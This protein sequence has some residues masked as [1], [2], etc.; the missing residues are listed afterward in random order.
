[1]HLQSKAVLHDHRGVKGKL[2]NE[3]FQDNNN[4]IISGQQQQHSQL[5]FYSPRKS[6]FRDRG[7]VG[8]GD[9][10]ESIVQRLRQTTR[11]AR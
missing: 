4:N 9:E 11:R 2:S 5:E 3:Q 6:V 1:L 8:V 10:R 7:G